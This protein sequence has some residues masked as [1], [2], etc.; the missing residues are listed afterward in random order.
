MKVGVLV[1]ARMGSSRLRDK[2]LRPVAGRPMLAYLLARI[3]REFG[4]EI[5]AGSVLPVVATGNA[6]R[7]GALGAL[8]QAN[9][10]AVYYGDDDNVPRRHVE[11]AA[12]LGLDAIV[13]VDGD[14]TFCD[15]QAMR[16][17]H[18]LLAGGAPLAKTSGL[19]LGMNS[20]GYSRAAL[21]AALE[22]ADLALLE[23]GWG[24]IF[25]GINADE[26]V[27][28]CPGAG[29]VRATLDYDADLA[30]FSRAIVEIPAWEQMDAA[31][32]VGQLIARGINHENLSVN[33]AYWENFSNGIS[34]ETKKDDA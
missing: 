3:T 1:T 24:R 6:D 8:A 28:D 18:D 34:K 29:Q 13:S 11:A 21:A 30:F 12:A 25:E 15:P 33:E 14:D 17:V 16:V 26:F 7:N 31:T 20:W 23:T 9:Q 32:L 22:Q 27:F 10:F 5:A 19:P 4:A 2:H